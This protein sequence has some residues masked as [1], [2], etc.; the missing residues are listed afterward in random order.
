MKFAPILKATAA[1]TLPA[2]ALLVAPVAVAADK[3]DT[4]YSRSYQD[5]TLASKQGRHYRIQVS[6]PVAAAPKDG[7]PVVYVMD[8][9]G[10]FGP[11][12]DVARMRE[13]E[14]LSPTIVVGIA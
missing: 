14:K 10:W 5:L 7:Y 12:V 3:E 9:N 6:V 4:S 11:A 8:G 1:V 13:Y 2:F